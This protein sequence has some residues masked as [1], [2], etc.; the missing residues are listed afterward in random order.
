MEFSYIGQ[1]DETQFIGASN[2]IN[3][4]LSDDAE[5][6]E[7]VVVTAL[8]IKREEKSLGYSVQRPKGGELTE[9]RES[10]ISNALSGKITGV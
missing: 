10:N 5:A 2:I 8:S 3:I 6:L 1:K 4:Q 9:A 7:E